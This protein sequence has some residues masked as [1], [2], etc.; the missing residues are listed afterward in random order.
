MKP[1]AVQSGCRG[2][3]MSDI[4][5]K[6]SEPIALRARLNE[7]W[8]AVAIGLVVFALALISVNGA[9]PVGLG[10]APRRCTLTCRERRSV[11]SPRPMPEARRWRCAARDLRRAA[12]RPERRRVHA[13]RR[14]QEFHAWPS[15]PSLPLPMQA[16]VAGSYAYVAAVTPADQQ[17]FEIGWS[18]KLTNQG[19]FVIALAV[20]ASSSPTSSRASP[21][22]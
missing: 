13:R 14:H 16:G 9:G 21:R 19:G 17:K 8:L 11:R 5:V 7:D 15:P 22:G 10:G 20:R 12:C 1:G 3:R 4:A 6:V 2:R 18:L